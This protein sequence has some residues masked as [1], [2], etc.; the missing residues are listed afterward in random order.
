M[1]KYSYKD[2]IDITYKALDF[3]PIQHFLKKDLTI[4]EIWNNIEGYQ[5]KNNQCYLNNDLFE[6]M[7]K[8]NDFFEGDIFN[9][10][11]EDELITYC[12]QRYPNVRWTEEIIIKNYIV[13]VGEAEC[14]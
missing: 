7:S 4:K 9:W 11:T 2:I 10:I 1:Q 8:Y 5:L 12:E 13:E 6:Y 3:I 14:S